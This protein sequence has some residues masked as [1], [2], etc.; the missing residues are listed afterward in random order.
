[1]PY[2]TSRLRQRHTMKMIENGISLL[3]RMDLL[4][5]EPADRLHQDQ[6]RMQELLR[7]TNGEAVTGHG[8]TA[9]HRRIP[10]CAT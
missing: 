5:L 4:H 7:R 1:M 6:R 2:M 8:P 10:A 9:L 3:H